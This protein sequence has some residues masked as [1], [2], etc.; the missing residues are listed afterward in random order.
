MIP[1]STLEAAQTLLEL[2]QA[3]WTW[4]R[5]TSSPKDIRY[6][7]WPQYHHSFLGSIS[8]TLCLRSSSNTFT[9]FSNAPH[10]EAYM[11]ANTMPRTGSF[12]NLWRLHNPASVRIREIIYWIRKRIPHLT[13]AWTIS[14]LHEANYFGQNLE[15]SEQVTHIVPPPICFPLLDII[16]SDSKP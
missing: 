7:I 4:H 9:T 6:W 5:Y 1:N 8:N 11:Y 12:P 15:S 13:F 16:L 10:L 14:M 2:F 3:H